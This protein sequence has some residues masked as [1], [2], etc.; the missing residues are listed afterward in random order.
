L[1]EVVAQFAPMLDVCPNRFS[2]FKFQKK[3]IK[4]ASMAMPWRRLVEI[5]VR[6]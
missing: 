6:N 3:S 4:N 2:R 5:A 1:R